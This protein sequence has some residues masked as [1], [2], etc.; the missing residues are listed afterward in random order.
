M[1]KKI[2]K[3]KKIRH[4]WSSDAL[5]TKSQRM[6]EEML[7]FGHEDWRC[8]LWSALS[9]ELLGRA[10]LAH[11]SPTLLAA[12]SKGDANKSKGGADNLIYAL[13]LTPRTAKFSPRSI[14]ASAVFGRLSALNPEFTAD[15]ADFSILH[16]ERRNEELHSGNSSFDG[17]GPSSWLPTYYRACT[18]LIESLGKNLEFLVGKDE[19]DAAAAMIAASLDES[20]KSV[21]KAIHQ[22]ETAWAAKASQD[23]E[24]LGKQ[25]KLWAKRSAGHRVICPACHSDALV[26][27][28]AIA[29]PIKTMEEDFVVETQKHLPSKFECIACGLKI[30]GLPQLAAA[31][32]GDTYTSTSGYDAADYYRTPYDEYEDDNNEY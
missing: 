6:F 24:T 27:G 15:L 5:L 31:K 3:P 13:G 30:S 20:A 25:A 26:S 32:L 18:V 7:Q 14:D 9:L 21:G 19:A 12:A 1:N 11:I 22:H 2:I 10:A 8:A 17:L 29:P 28:E 16:L 23:Q 4:E